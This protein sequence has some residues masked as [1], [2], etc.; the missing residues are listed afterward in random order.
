MVLTPLYIRTCGRALYFVRGGM[1]ADGTR[2]PEST[3]A[4]ATPPGASLGA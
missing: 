2:F 1:E 4:Q 3:K